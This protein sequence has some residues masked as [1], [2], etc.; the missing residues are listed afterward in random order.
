VLGTKKSPAH[1]DHKVVQLQPLLGSTMWVKHPRS[2]IAF[3][4]FHRS[5]DVR[6]KMVKRGNVA[7]ADL[8]CQM[9]PMLGLCH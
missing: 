4:L 2:L 7:I 5:N 8:G 6:F 3:I 9:S 1:D